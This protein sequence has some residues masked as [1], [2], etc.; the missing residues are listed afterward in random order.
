[1]NA[2][3]FQ[4]KLEKDTHSEATSFVVPFDVQK[5]FGTRAQV[6]VR[7][8]IN[9]YPLRTS[10]TPIG[11]IKWIE[12]EQELSERLGRKVDMGSVLK[13]RIR[14]YVEEEMVVIYEQPKRQR[15]K[16]KGAKKG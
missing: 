7:G 2:Q 15:L 13:K 12:L 1:M 6:K 9:G 3:K 16:S 8:T 4:V 14:P 10:I 5:V 11:L